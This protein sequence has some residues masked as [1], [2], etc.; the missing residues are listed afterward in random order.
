MSVLTIKTQKGERKIGPGYPCFVVAEVS[1]NHLQQRD[2]AKE[3]VRAAAANGA[4]AIKLQ[5]YTPD[6]ITMNVRNDYF[7]LGGK[8]NPASWKGKNL[9]ELYSLAFTPWEWHKE[10]L[11][12]AKSLGIV[13]FS[14][15]FDETAV[16]FLE[17]LHVPLYKIASYEMTHVPLVEKVAKTGKPLIMSV[18]FSSEEEA[19]ESV[20]AFRRAGGKDLAL[21]HCL[22]TYADE[23][24]P[25][26]THLSTVRDLAEKFDVVSGFSDNNG[27][28]YF[29]ILAAA[30]GASIIEKHLVISHTDESFDKRFSIDPA[31]LK[32]MVETIRRNEKAMGAPHYG[33]VNDA[34]A[35][36]LRLRRS[37]FA[38][39]DIKK[40]EVFTRGNIRVVRPSFGLAPKYFEKVIGK[41]AASDIKRGDPIQKELIQGGV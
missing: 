5:T 19:H 25:K 14:S 28:T 36:N 38:E 11:D 15:P 32:Q 1:C 24:D 34:E 10:L 3:I 27:G 37:I 31:E 22:N 26:D 33:P 23:S 18:G 41:K 7:M 16:D 40:G 6:T 29:S 13:G 2:K 4:D 20:D 21:L 17:G 9:Y 30:A 8:D 12:L 39:K 35:Y